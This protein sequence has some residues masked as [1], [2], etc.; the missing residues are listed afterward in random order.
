[1]RS[2]L[3][4]TYSALEKPQGMSLE[5]S[6]LPAKLAVLVSALVLLPEHSP[7]LIATPNVN[8]SM[9]ATQ[10]LRLSA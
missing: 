3:D 5:R 8:Q 9:T 1:M 4:A 10:A 7:A 2:L 6:K